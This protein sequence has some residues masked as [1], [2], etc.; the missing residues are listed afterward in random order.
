SLGNNKET[1]QEYIL[2]PLHP[3]RPRISAEDV[4]EKEEQHNL[5][6][7]EQA[8]KDDLEKLVTEEMV[9]KAIDNAT[10]QAFEEEK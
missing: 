10:R 4:A 8:L 2:L 7:A 3:H 6:E 5:I 1:P 9:A